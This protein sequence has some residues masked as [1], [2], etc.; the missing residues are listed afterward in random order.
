MNRTMTVPVDTRPTTRPARAD[1]GSGLLE[2]EQVAC[3]LC[4]ESR[5]R[6]LFRE[7]Y[8]LG[9][10]AA[11][12]HVVRCRRCGLVYVSPRLTFASTG[13]V[14]RHDAADTISHGYCWQG[15]RGGSRFRRLLQRL[16]RMR[17]DGR[18]LD[19]GCGG[20]QFLA[21][22]RRTGNWDLLGIE[23]HAPAAR[24][25]RQLADCT[26]HTGTLQQTPLE[27]GSFDVVAMLGVLEHLH[28]PTSTLR[29]VREL[30]KPGGVLAVYVPSFDYLRIKD[31]GWLSR[32]RTGRHS[33]LHPQ[34]HL[35]HFTPRTLA[36]ML[37]AAGFEPPDLDVGHPF[38]HGGPAKRTI[39]K[40]AY[41]AARFLRA[42]TGLHL[43]GLEAVARTT[44]P[45]KAPELHS[46]DPTDAI[47]GR[48]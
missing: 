44:Q 48:L 30:L 24:S 41:Y 21:E 46:G 34:E 36:T 42:T 13:H 8:R 1:L 26:V 28:D 43:G 15:E 10:E 40:T 11:R 35:F 18:L 25:A 14:Y 45:P 9:T 31:T 4:G 20:G 22:A 19:V 23:P 5:S 37:T 16:I 27:P 32:L 12:L 17:G 3:N 29:R 33:N 47:G 6:V 39:K 7:T 2:T 38:M